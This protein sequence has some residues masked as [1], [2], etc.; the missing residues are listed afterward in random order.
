MCKKIHDNF[1]EDLEYNGDTKFLFGSYKNKTNIIPFTEDQDVDVLI[2]L[3]YEIFKQ[4]DWYESNWQWAL[5]QKMREI[6][7]EKYPT[8][9]WIKAWWKVVLIKFSDNTH[10]IELLPA[11]EQEDKSFLIPDSENQE[12]V[13]F[14]PRKQIDIFK[15]SNKETSWLTASLIRMIKSWRNNN[16]TLQLK[17]YTIEK[18]VINFLEDYDYEEKDKIEIIYNF[19]IFMKE[20]CNKEQES[21][22]ESA[23]WNL[24]KTFEYIKNDKEKKAL[25]ELW[26][27]FWWKFPVT[28]QKIFEWEENVNVINNSPKLWLSI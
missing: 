4:Y 20:N 5:L 16:S 13:S 23:I 22:I 2:K 6:L 21:F 19:F 28:I 12:W 9:E 1:Y 18:Y 14:N 3:P 11:F 8:T 10:N 17:S 15:N 24:D 26:K 7:K 25:E 27:I